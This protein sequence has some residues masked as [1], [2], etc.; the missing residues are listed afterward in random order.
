M[1]C[2]SSQ[3][4]DNEHNGAPENIIP[5][6]GNKPLRK[7]NLSWT[8]DT[9]I[10]LEELQAKR[11][12]F[13]ETASTY[14]GRSEVWEKLRTACETTDLAQAQSIVDSLNLSV[15]TGHLSDGCYD[16]LGN[17]YLTPIYCFVEPTNLTRTTDDNFKN[18]TET[19]NTENEPT[20][21]KYSNSVPLTQIPTITVTEHDD[22][23]EEEEE[24]E[25]SYEPKA[26]PLYTPP[27]LTTSTTD[28]SE[29]LVIRLNTGKD[30]RV[31]V[32]PEDTMKIVKSRLCNS[33]NVDPNTVNIRLIYMGKILD[34]NV[35]VEDTKVP[36]G[37]VIQ[38]LVVL[39]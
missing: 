2:C 16:E 28:S 11:V 1:G 15:P 4:A 31:K 39:V 24:P 33:E 7:K 8:S 26:E 36:R 3:L 38:A 32:N 23:E 13:W 21:R 9:P 25:I 35:T 30:V 29:E 19:Q 17:R 10:T 37:G 22:D 20:N 12:A 34:D 14:E 18:S 5:S 27:V 6:S